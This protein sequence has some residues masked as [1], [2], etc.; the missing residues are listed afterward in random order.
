MEHDSP[1]GDFDGHPSTGLAPSPALW[2]FGERTLAA[3]LATLVVAYVGVAAFAAWQFWRAGHTAADQDWQRL[4][5][6][7]IILFFV[8]VAYAGATIVGPTLVR[9]RP[10]VRQMRAENDRG[11]QAAIAGDGQLAPLATGQPEP[12]LASEI[13]VGTVKFGPFGSWRRR[14]T[15]PSIAQSLVVVV[16]ASGMIAAVVMV[17]GLVPFGEEFPSIPLAN[18]FAILIVGLAALIGLTSVAQIVLSVWMLA[19]GG[20]D[21]VPH[22]AADDW[23]M[24]QLGGRRGR[25]QPI[26]WHEIRAFYQAEDRLRLSGSQITP[27]P[28]Q[29]TTYTVDT[30]DRQLRWSIWDDSTPAQ[31][32]DGERLCR[33]VV[34]RTRLPLRDLSAVA[35]R[36]AIAAMELI[37][38]F[39]GLLLGRRFVY[40]DPASSSPPRPGALAAR[41]VGSLRTRRLVVSGLALAIFSALLLGVGMIAPVIQSWRATP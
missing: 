11:Q 40:Q 31:R 32:A 39:A 29:Q 24:R 2:R 9:L 17:P 41:P 8:A 1:G 35:S 36:Q 7:L 26:P 18:G 21:P 19:H 38:P 20:G 12:L 13:P 10:F 23:G 28:A 3:G 27:G 25:N 6:T 5:I 34:T 30:G 14:R 16:I 4:M 22:F 33:L 15:R 37:A